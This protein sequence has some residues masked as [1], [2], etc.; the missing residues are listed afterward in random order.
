ML[1]LKKR[2]NLKIDL[3]QITGFILAFFTGFTLAF[4]TGN[5]SSLTDLGQ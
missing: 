3:D 1:I 5:T 2:K 4:F